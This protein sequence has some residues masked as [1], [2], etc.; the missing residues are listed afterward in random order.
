MFS[1]ELYCG[2]VK[3]RA[4][5]G[6]MFLESIWQISSFTK[7]IIV[8]F[9]K[10]NG[11]KMHNMLFTKCNFFQVLK[12]KKKKCDFVVEGLTLSKTSSYFN[13]SAEQVF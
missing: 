13:V 4:C 10:I 2:H 11:E 6:K 8:D 9:E 5:L 7:I 3:T 1:K 12:K